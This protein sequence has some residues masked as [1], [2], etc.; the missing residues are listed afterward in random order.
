[1]DNRKGFTV[2]ELSIAFAVVGFLLIVF[3]AVPNA[4]RQTRNNNR[5]QDVKALA[6]ALKEK[7]VVSQTGA[8]PESC[9]NTQH[10]CFSRQANLSYYDNTSNRETY[11]TYYRNAAKLNELAPQLDVEDEAVI[12][13]VLIHSYATC[14][15][16][17][18]QGGNA[19]P[20]S[21]AIQYA[22]ETM[23]GPKLQCKN[24]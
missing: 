9:N 16:D 1:M 17:V 18:L 3:I 12:S 8:L 6:A 15:R 2:V 5:V 14:E 11:I 13:K 23:S 10:N 21:V 20:T 22:V 19:S 4:M 7:Q 24:V